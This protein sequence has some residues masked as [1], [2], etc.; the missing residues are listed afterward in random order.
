MAQRESS[1]FSAV[2][3]PH[4]IQLQHFLMLWWV[5]LCDYCSCFY[6]CRRPL[7]IVGPS[8]PVTPRHFS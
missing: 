3:D 6:I 2:I 7:K 4:D 5:L 1:F 8:M